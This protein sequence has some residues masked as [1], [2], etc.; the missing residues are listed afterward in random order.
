VRLQ[1][2][3]PDVRGGRL[4]PHL[5]KQLPHLVCRQA[6]IARELHG[7]VPNLG[8]PPQRAHEIALSLSAHRVQLQCH[9]NRCHASSSL[10]NLPRH[11]MVSSRRRE[12][13]M[14]AEETWLEALATYEKLA[15]G[16][17]HVR[18]AGHGPP[19]CT[20]RYR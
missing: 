11:L 17:G 9:R 8:D 3:E 20:W 4:Q 16:A 14:S 7:G 6:A 1:G 19:G 12:E 5:V 13:P 15:G 18:E 10:L 2:G